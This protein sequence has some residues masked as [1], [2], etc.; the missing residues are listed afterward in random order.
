MA[1]QNESALDKLK[2]EKD[3]ALVAYLKSLGIDPDYVG[4]KDDKRRVVIK[5]LQVVFKDHPTPQTLS[6]ATDEDVKN[7]KKTP[8]HIKEGA[9][10]KMKILFRVQ[11]DAVAG[12]KVEN[13]V[14]KM[15]KEIKDVEMLGSFPPSNDW[16]TLEIPRQG[17]NEAPEGALLRGDYSAT[18][19]FTDDDKLEH[20]IV[21]YAIHI[22]KEFGK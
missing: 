21:K 2:G 10:Y 1:D 18:M 15:G 17:W 6:F 22:G 8:L 7:A 11:H 9:E 3:P 5:E 19:K 4:P 20:L 13:T 12:F 16:K 14:S